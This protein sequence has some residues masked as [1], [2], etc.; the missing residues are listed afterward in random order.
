M[1]PGAKRPPESRPEPFLSI[2]LS[3]IGTPLFFRSKAKLPHL[4][5]FP[6]SCRPCQFA[7]P[8]LFVIAGAHGFRVLRLPFIFSLAKFSL[9]LKVLY[10][11]R[12]PCRIFPLFILGKKPL[13]IARL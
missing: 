9:L 6:K 7:A 13:G 5:C 10:E 2:F 11:T 12:I 1:H 3:A 4:R 8:V